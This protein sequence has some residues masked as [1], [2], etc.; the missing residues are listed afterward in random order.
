MARDVVLDFEATT[1]SYTV[2]VS[3]SDGKDATGGA[4]AAADATISVTIDVTDVAE[5]PAAPAA[6]TVTSPTSDPD[7]SLAVAWSAPDTTGKPKISG[8]DV[9]YRV[10]GNLGW[11]SA[12]HSGTVTTTTLTGLTAGTSYEVQVLAYNGEGSSPWSA[13]GSGTTTGNGK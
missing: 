7:T 8:Y 4:D 3:V 12:V 13:A 11:S 2:T 6:P 10:Q 5:P 1:S 9:R